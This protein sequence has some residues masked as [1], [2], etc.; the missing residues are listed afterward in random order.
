[1]APPYVLERI[2]AMTAVEERA[3]AS[4]SKM[5]AEIKAHPQCW[6]SREEMA[7]DRKAINLAMLTGLD[8]ADQRMMARTDKLV[9][10][11]KAL[12][13]ED[14]KARETVMAR[15]RQRFGRLQTALFP[16]DDLSLALWSP[17][18]LVDEM[19]PRKAGAQFIVIVAKRGTGKTTLARPLIERLFSSG[20]VAGVTVMSGTD[21]ITGD[22]DFLRRSP[23]ARIMGFS[24]DGITALI[25][26]QKAAGA[27]RVDQLLVVDDAMGNSEAER[28]Q[29]LRDLATNGRNLGIYVIIISQS[30]THVLS[31]AART[32]ADYVLF[33]ALT[34]A[35]IKE[36]ESDVFQGITATSAELKAFIKLNTSPR[37]PYQFAA[38][39]TRPMSRIVLCAAEPPASDAEPE[40]FAEA[41]EDDGMDA[42]VV[43]ARALELDD[44]EEGAFVQAG[45]PA[46]EELEER[47]DGET[48]APPMR[49]DEAEEDTVRSPMGIRAFK[50]DAEAIPDLYE[51]PTWAVHKLLSFLREREWL[52]STE[53][54]WEACNGG[55]RISGV[56]E[57]AGFNV[58]KTDLFFCEG[59]AKRS[60]L[61][62]QPET[63]DAMIT[64]PPYQFKTKFLERAVE[65]GKKWFMLLPIEAMG[66]K[67]RADLYRAG[68]FQFIVETT[69]VE[70]TKKGREVAISAAMVWIGGGWSD[71]PEIQWLPHGKGE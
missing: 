64:N 15:N 40:V 54:V 17:Q 3:F 65:L 7:S 48:T 1:M 41:A 42:L 20:R 46:R 19:P 67:G 38:Y 13:L 8:A 12:S 31:P 11:K 28:S 26:A 53:T 34:D 71:K 33:A 29:P 69:P 43:K 49:D 2:A 32:N 18:R 58:I 30:L 36:L 10:E 66:S 51:T 21:S 45:M 47:G 16:S 52:S 44:E 57:E 59:D 35:Q 9:K 27:A 39:I 63:W 24:N 68:A 56:L 6:T 25:K 22:F 60:Y 23:S 62:W 14:A 4:W 50:A 5:L 61:D 55:G 70:F 37:V